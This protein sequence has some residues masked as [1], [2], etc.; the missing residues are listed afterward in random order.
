MKTTFHNRI[1]SDVASA[2][3]LWSSVFIACCRIH[4]SVCPQ[5]CACGRRSCGPDWPRFHVIQYRASYCRNHRCYSRCGNTSMPSALAGLRWRKAWVTMRRVASIARWCVVFFVLVDGIPSRGRGAISKPR[6][7]CD[8][9]ESGG[10]DEWRWRGWLGGGWL[11]WG[12]G[13][14]V[15]GA[16]GCRGCGGGRFLRRSLFGRG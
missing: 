5:F 10:C 13:G 4:T 15:Y 12:S 3:S 9:W 14:A 2:G 11:F 16:T 1:A 8:C 6:G 7:C